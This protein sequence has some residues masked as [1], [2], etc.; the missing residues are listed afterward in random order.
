[1]G[2]DRDYKLKDIKEW[3]LWFIDEMHSDDNWSNR[4]IFII[5]TKT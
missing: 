2:K 4:L 5:K 1:M 3:F